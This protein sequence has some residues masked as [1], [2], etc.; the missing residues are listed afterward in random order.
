MR[1]VTLTTAAVRLHT[2]L[3]QAPSSSAR[4]RALVSVIK[5][6][7]FPAVPAGGSR[8]RANRHRTSERV[9]AAK[10]ASRHPPLCSDGWA[11]PNAQ[12]VRARTRTSA[13]ASAAV[14]QGRGRGGSA[15]RRGACECSGFAGYS[16]PAGSRFGSHRLSHGSDGRRRD[17]YRRCTVWRRAGRSTAHFQDPRCKRTTDGRRRDGTWSTQPARAGRP[18]ATRRFPNGATEM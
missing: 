7:Y 3:F 5:R 13:D 4:R 2:N 14:C 1:R 18:A 12:P 17:G 16:D 6:Y 10:V 15:P 11:P 8:S 9:V